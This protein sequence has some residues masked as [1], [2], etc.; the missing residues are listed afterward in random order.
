VSELLTIELVPK[1]AWF[2][3]VRAVVSKEDWDK[4]KKI[5]RTRAGNVCEICG[6]RGPRWPVECHEVFEYDDA[7]HVQRLACLIALCPACHEVKHMGFAGVRGRGRTALA[8]LARVNKWSL[9]DARLYVEA[10]FEQWHRRSCH[11][12]TLDLSYLE[13]F[14]VNVNSESLSNSR[15]ATQRSD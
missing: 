6:G 5:T 7:R 8:H 10:C 14:D 9:S 4:L 13:Q 15:G 11:E 3:N 12:W 1:T 2:R